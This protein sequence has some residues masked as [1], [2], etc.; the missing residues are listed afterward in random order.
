MQLLS[1]KDKIPIFK[2]QAKEAKKVG[3]NSQMC[4]TMSTRKDWL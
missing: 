2:E 4:S 1:E 3:G